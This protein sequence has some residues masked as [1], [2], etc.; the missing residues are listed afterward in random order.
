[1]AAARVWCVLLLLQYSAT[2]CRRL[3]RAARLFSGLL[4]FCIKKTKETAENKEQIATPLAFGV[5]IK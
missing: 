4:F 5:G 2:C 3:D 1:M